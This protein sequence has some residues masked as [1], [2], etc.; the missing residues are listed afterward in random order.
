MSLMEKLETVPKGILIGVSLGI[1]VLLV[2]VVGY[3]LISPKNTVP[4]SAT[5]E[6]KSR[7]NTGTVGG[8]GTPHYNQMVEA[9]NQQKAEEAAA[10]G[11]SFIPLPIGNPQDVASPQSQKET[12][13]AKKAPPPQRP[14]RQQ[15][16]IVREGANKA[17]EADLK[18]LLSRTRVGSA[19]QPYVLMVEAATPD[20]DGAS[21]A[22]TARTARNGSRGSVALASYSDSE[23]ETLIQVKKELRPGKI[24]YAINDLGINTDSPSPVMAT[25]ARGPL[26]GAKAIGAFQRNGTS[27]VLAYSRLVLSS[28]ETINITGVA[29]DPTT[30]QTDVASDHDTHFFQRWGSLIA[31]SFLEGF[32]KAMTNKN[33]ST[34]VDTGNTVVIDS[35]DKSYKDV[36]LEAFGKVGERSANILERGFDRPPTVYLN[37]G[38]PVG[39]LLMDVAN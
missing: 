3:L 28:G 17:F 22:G 33:Q 23:P 12:S 35:K 38:Q 25:V 6:M 15:T 39:I 7:A 29:I 13:V 2:T 18:N 31:A 11:E 19:G 9:L 14:N 32:G 10:K 37:A 27:L 1:L 5:K 21:N 8:E 16:T 34:T 26:K 24:L 36:T 30:Q 4:P 20:D